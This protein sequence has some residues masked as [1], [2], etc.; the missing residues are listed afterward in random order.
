MPPSRRQPRTTP[1]TRRPRVA[2]LR[3]P[4]SAQR[5]E[6][7]PRPAE[8]DDLDPGATVTEPELAE[9]EPAEPEPA[10]TGPVIGAPEPVAHEWPEPEEPAGPDPDEPVVD[11]VRDDDTAEDRPAPRPRPAGKR[12]SIG[13]T[14]P[15]DLAE[16]EAEAAGTD[17]ERAT[18]R[19]DNTLSVAIVLAVVALLLAGLAIWFRGE[20]NSRSEAADA[21]NAALTD[22]GRAVEVTDQVR[23]ALERTLSFNYADLDSTEKAV[24]ENLAGKASCEYEQLFGEVRKLAPEQKIVVTA[25]VRD[26]GLVRLEGDKAVLLA[27]VD[28]RS[29][30][31][32]QNQAAVSGAQFTVSAERQDDR[33]KITGFD[34]L[35]QPLAGGKPAPQC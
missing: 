19:R 12:R 11:T 1:P 20:A 8:I 4:D 9:P 14:Q 34:L 30:R 5:A 21:D 6:P 10:L 3:R 28:Q 25:Q 18:P 13:I 26:L 7:D 32:D 17:P 31:A 33:W 27:F 24:R 16:A 22:P 35:G 15:G 29:T 2:G 23:G